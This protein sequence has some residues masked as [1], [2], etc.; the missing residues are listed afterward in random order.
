M[1]ES[2]F[3]ALLPLF[4]FPIPV[5]TKLFCYSK[6]E[7]NLY[8][9]HSYAFKMPIS[10]VFMSKR[11]CEVCV[12]IRIRTKYGKLKNRREQIFNKILFE[13]YFNSVFLFYYTSYRRLLFLRDSH[14]MWQANGH[15][16]LYLITSIIYR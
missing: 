7:G 5:I 4:T 6:I 16:N 2:Y 3:C 12:S 10:I 1:I 8:S 11:I 13:Y 14:S 9:H 15:S